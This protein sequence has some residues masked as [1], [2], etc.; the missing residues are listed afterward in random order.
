MRG[1][2]QWVRLFRDQERLTGKTISDR[3]ARLAVVQVYRTCGAVVNG[4]D[5][6]TVSYGGYDITGDHS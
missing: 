5:W 3:R 4:M 1:S 6:L 2:L